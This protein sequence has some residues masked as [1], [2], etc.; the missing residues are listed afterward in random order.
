MIII[1]ETFQ[2]AGNPVLHLNYGVTFQDLVIVITEGLYHSASVVGF[3]HHHG[4]SA[5]VSRNDDDVGVIL[6]VVEC[7]ALLKGQVGFW[8][9]GLS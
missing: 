2:S 7:L 5:F 9:L 1:V 4:S 3:V 6:Q 8:W